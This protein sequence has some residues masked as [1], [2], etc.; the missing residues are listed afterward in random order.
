MT[1]ARESAA[2][3]EDEVTPPVRLKTVRLGYD[4]A[5]AWEADM[6]DDVREHAREV[7]RHDA[8]VITRWIVAAAIIVAFVVVA[9]DNRDDV[10]VGYVVGDVEAPI[11]LVLLIAVAVGLVLGWLTRFR[12]RT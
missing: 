3:A 4:A 7:H 9:L 10:R 1:W 5:D 11:W 6:D 2:L 12:R 8:W